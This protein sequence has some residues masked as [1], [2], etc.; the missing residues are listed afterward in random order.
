MRLRIR[1]VNSPSLVFF[2]SLVYQGLKWAV[3]KPLFLSFFAVDGRELP[4]SPRLPP[5]IGFFF[6]SR[7]ACCNQVTNFAWWMDE[8]A[9]SAVVFNGDPFPCFSEK[10]RSPFFWSF[11]KPTPSLPIKSGDFTLNNQKILPAFLSDPSPFPFPPPGV[12]SEVALIGRI[13]PFGWGVTPFSPPLRARG[14]FF[15][16]LT[17]YATTSNLAREE[18]STF[19]PFFLSKAPSSLFKVFAFP[20]L[21]FELETLDSPPSL[22][23]TKKFLRFLFLFTAIMRL[24]DQ[25]LVPSFRDGPPI[26]F[27][28]LESILPVPP[29]Q[30]PL[31]PSKLVCRSLSLSFPAR[32]NLLPSSSLALRGL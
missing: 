31:R 3:T 28:V 32:R 24:R 17:I 7:T 21:A 26:F 19:A 18:Y 12:D 14:C 9:Y 5:Q 11:D 4:F 6:F 29:S 20:R 8:G 13:T 27:L 25:P 15:P 2:F 23:E 16:A 10:F 22:S 1:S 30:P